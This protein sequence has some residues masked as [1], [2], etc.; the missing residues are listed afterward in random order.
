MWTGVVGGG[1]G[2]VGGAGRTVNRSRGDLLTEATQVFE[3]RVERL[4]HASPEK[5]GSF[6]FTH[7]VAEMT[8]ARVEK[9]TELRAGDRVFVRHW[10]KRWIGK[11]QLPPDHYGHRTV[12]AVKQTVVVFVSGTRQTGYD[13]LSPN[14]YF[15]VVTTG[16]KLPASDR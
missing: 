6:E 16:G 14:G 2:V 4:Y 15:E 7:S 10:H 3:G 9:G 5:E 1:G 12:P 13:V 8:V 11:G